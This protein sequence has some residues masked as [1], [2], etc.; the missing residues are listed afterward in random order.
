[1]VFFILISILLL[2]GQLRLLQFTAN[3][4][5]P[6]HLFCISQIPQ[7]SHSDASE[8]MSAFLCGEKIHSAH[9]KDFFSRSSMYHLIVVAKAHLTAVSCVFLWLCEK[10]KNFYFL[11]LSAL[12]TIAY[13]LSCGPQAPLMRA[14]VY[15]LLIY[16]SRKLHLGWTRIFSLM[17]ATLI[18]LVLDPT[19]YDSLA[20][21]HSSSCAL[22]FLLAEA[23]GFYS[24]SAFV[25]S[26]FATLP[27]L[28]GWAN[29][30]PLGIVMNVLLAPTLFV[31]WFSCSLFS[32]L[33]PG[34]APWTSEAIVRSIRYCTLLL[35]PI[36][37][38]RQSQHLSVVFLWTLFW[39]GCLI[40][41]LRHRLRRSTRQ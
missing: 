34:V 31:F 38:V 5:Q 32:L 35:D 23:C 7:V 40:L 3:F 16:S 24:A 1:M 9:W 19:W 18:C 30:H 6:L 4:F 10:W 41:W 12:L 21:L 27:F 22:A 2:C 15:L 17:L 29:L 13:I 37:T 33:I 14:G 25:F 26:Y 11:A 36:P 28:W 20:L 39:L 8:I